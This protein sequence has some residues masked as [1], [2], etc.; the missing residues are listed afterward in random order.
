MFGLIT[1]LALA[2][3]SGIASAAPVLTLNSTKVGDGDYVKVTISNVSS[4]TIQD[5][6]GLYLGAAPNPNL[7]APVKYQWAA[8]TPAYLTTGNASMT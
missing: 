5:T 3:F 2:T 8:N 7:Q 4:P 1:C 6:V